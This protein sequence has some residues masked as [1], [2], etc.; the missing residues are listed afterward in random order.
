MRSNKVNY[1]VARAQL[2][3]L[4]R[5][6]KKDSI[7]RNLSSKKEPIKTQKEIKPKFIESKKDKPVVKKQM[8]ESEI[9]ARKRATKIINIAKNQGISIKDALKRSGAP[10]KVRNEVLRRRPR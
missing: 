10:P 1:D 9:K 6:V 4:V 8:S 5:F 2:D 7:I 3:H